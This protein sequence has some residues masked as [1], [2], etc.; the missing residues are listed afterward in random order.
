MNNCFIV[1]LFNGSKANNIKKR[2][3]YQCLY[4]FL[5]PQNL[6]RMKTKY[7]ILLSILSGILLSI[8]WPVNGFTPLIFIALVPLF[9][10]QQY[11]GDTNKK[12]MFWY[13]WLTFLIW[14]VLTTWWIWNS[15]QGGALTAFILNSLFTAVV[16]QLYHLSKKKL[17]Y[18]KRGMFI[19]VFYWVTWE[20]MHMNWDLT[21]SWL[22]LGNVFASKHTWIQWYEYTG[23]LG[24]TIWILIA[25]IIVYKIISG[26]VNKAKPV[27]T[28]IS[29]IKLVIIVA[30]PIIFSLSIYHNYIEEENPVDIIA[31]QPNIDPYNEQYTLTYRELLDRNLDLTSRLINDSTDFVLFPE[32]ALQED[33]W[34]KRID[35]SIS[36]RLL[37]KVVEKFPNTAFVVGATTYELILLGEEKTNAARKFKNSLDHYYAFNTAILIENEQDY[38][39][40]HKSKLTP[41]AE[42]M[43]S[44]GI[45]KPIENLAIDLGGTTG[46]LGKEDHPVSFT[47]VKD[48]I[49]ASP[50]ICY[51]SVYGE[52]VA[53]SV[54][55]GA[56]LI[57]VITNDG[58]W[59]NTPGYKQHFLFSVLRAIE[60]RRSVARSANTG[61]S[62][63]INQRGDILQQTP[64]WETAVISQTLNAN[65][66]LTYYT[67]NGDYIGRVSAFATA[68]LMLIAFT[69][70]YLRRKQTNSKN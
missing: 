19:L 5:R 57:F 44:W 13:A 63:F 48:S 11:V 33:I 58:W 60:T 17:F 6:H 56:G 61:I 54:K 9:F 20:Y 41:G 4:L 27:N 35:R 39:L 49:G 14:N 55:Q 18:N 64:Y 28:I 51:E 45:L 69:Q 16:F 53:N 38:Q 46:T 15:T 7:L 21:W 62:A 50:I 1:A 3:V 2:A 68:L 22:N 36:L 59:G 12:G 30:V 42:I 31:V 65:Y 32:S 34:E 8:S 40:H 26:L 23:S 70:G 52:F 24:G 43:P 10:I 25:N 47:K 37:Q 29:G 67:K 66:K